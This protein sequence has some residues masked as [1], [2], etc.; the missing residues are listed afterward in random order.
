MAIAE[1]GT[2]DDNGVGSLREALER[3]NNGEIDVLEFFLPLGSKIDVLSALPRLARPV[4]IRF[5]PTGGKRGATEGFVILDGSGCP[6]PCDG[7]TLAGGGS[8]VNDLQIQNF[9][10][11][12]LVLETA[13]GNTVQHNA[14]LGNGL[15]GVH[16]ASGD[17]NRVGGTGPDEANTITGNGGPG[18][19]VTE[20]TGHTFSANM[21]ADNTGLGIELA[22]V[23]ANDDLDADDGP[24]TGQNYPL[25][26]AVADGSTTIEG[27]LH[28]T[29]QT[30]F[31]LEFVANASCD[32][33]GLGEGALYLGTT[34]IATDANGNADFVASFDADADFIAATAT[35]PDGSTSGFSNCLGLADPCNDPTTVPFWDS[36]FTSNGDGTGTIPLSAPAGFSVIALGEPTTNLTLLQPQTPDG[37]P[38]DDFVAVGDDLPPGNTRW[39][40][41]GLVPPTEVLLPIAAPDEASSSFFLEISDACPVP[42]TLRVDPALDLFETPTDV[43]DEALPTVYALAQNYPN[44]FNPVTRIGFALPEPQDVRLEVFDI[45][46]RRVAVLVDDRMAPGRHEVVWDA[47]SMPSGMYLYRMVAGTFVETRRLTLLK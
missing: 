38:I 17:Q 42:R 21:I 2:T 36:T 13:G 45:L 10:G 35:A 6:A 9:P 15:G 41:T 30:T 40:Y 16:I 24:N 20:G 7:L 12:G 8:L 39:Q 14:L 4:S 3:L 28:S 46:G 32:A 27:T 47:A 34:L 33:S 1:V 44:P 18:I 23:G 43:E 22:G 19:L 26:T 25:I 11:F 37:T 29:P 31:T 5:N